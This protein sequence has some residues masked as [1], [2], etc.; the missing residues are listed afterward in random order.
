M[1]EI[2]RDQIYNGGSLTTSTASVQETSNKWTNP[3]TSLL[4]DLCCE[5]Y[6]TLFQST[7]MKNEKVIN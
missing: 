7:T 1:E 4:I 2:E 6:K 3:A 5:K